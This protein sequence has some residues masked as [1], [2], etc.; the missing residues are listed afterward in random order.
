MLRS[1]FDN[2]VIINARLASL[3]R[4]QRAISSLDR[5]QPLQRPNSKSKSQISLQGELMRSSFINLSLYLLTFS[6][7]DRCK[8]F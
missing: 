7:H 3:N 1:L 4:V 5:P 8:F 6:A 2:S